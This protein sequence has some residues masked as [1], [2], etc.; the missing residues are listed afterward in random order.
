VIDG[1]LTCVGAGG[2]RSSRPLA[3]WLSPDLRELAHEDA[4]RWIKR[5]RLVPFDDVPMRRRFTYRGDSLWWFTE[6]YLHKMRRV[7]AAVR[8]VLALDAA[9]AALEPSRLEIATR[10]AAVRAAARAFGRARTIPLS[11]VDMPSRPSSESSWAGWLVGATAYL[12]RLKP[13]PR[14]RSP[15]RGGVAAFVHTAFW[16]PAAD[17]A[18]QE[19]YVGPVLA[20]IAERAGRDELACVGVGPRRQFRAR[21]WWD[22]LTAADAGPRIVAIEQLAPRRA[23]ADA[24]ELWRRRDALARAITSG[25][26]IRAAAEYRGCDLWSVLEPELARVARVQW[27]WS[28]RAMDEAAAALDA[29]DPRIVLTYAE[30]G[31]WGRA[32]MLEARRRGMPSVGLQHG[33][34]HR[35]WLNYRHEPDEMQADEAGG[36]FPR[37]DV[38]LVFDGYAAAYLRSAGHFPADAIAITGSPRLDGFAA[39]V[40]ALAPERERL[41]ETLAVGAGS[42]V[43]LAAKFSEI[44]AELPA[45]FDAVAARTSTHLVVKPHPADRADDYQRVAGDR[46]R[47]TIAAADADLGRLLAAADAVATMNSTVAIDAMVLGIPALVVGL[48]NNLG[49]FVDAGVMFGA[50]RASLGTALETLLYDRAVR[51]RWRERAAAFAD[52][53]AMRATGDAAR[54]AADAILSRARR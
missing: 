38:T 44:H 9:C 24:L 8:T 40:R 10:D 1:T 52:A 42:L 32:L 5:L 11:D 15:H 34:I 2:A 37:P 13:A 49:P 14:E 35:H 6:L 12:S 23:L 54:R 47:I 26:A 50:D 51:E 28:A 22:P 41:R 45:L 7:D 21:R 27:T 30:A 25:P 4:Y 43:V 16:R 18:N 20:A 29:L 46:P 33:F 17:D 3:D 48:P 53:H 36:G 19:H 31:G 39:R